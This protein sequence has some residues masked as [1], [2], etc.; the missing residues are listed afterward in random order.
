MLDAPDEPNRYEGATVTPPTEYPLLPFSEEL[1]KNTELKTPRTFFKPRKICVQCGEREAT[2]NGR[3][4]KCRQIYQRAWYQKNKEAQ[5]ARVAETNKM[6]KAR[7][8]DFILN[9][10]CCPCMDCKKRFHPAAMEFDHA[11]GKKKFEISRS[12]FWHDEAALREE[13]AKCDLVCAN[14]HRVRTMVRLREKHPTAPYLNHDFYNPKL[15]WRKRKQLNE[16]IRTIRAENI[17]HAD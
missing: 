17:R 5:K 10:K 8:A 13:L 12:A 16:L 3:C 1:P 11:R 2:S 7:I 4:W 9:L 14:C 6:R 15:H